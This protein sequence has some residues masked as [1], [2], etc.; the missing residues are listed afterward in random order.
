MTIMILNLQPRV[1]VTIVQ[2][3]IATLSIVINKACYT[4]CKN[5]Y[6]QCINLGMDT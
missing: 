4:S 3:P 6:K 5:L 1:K 2:T